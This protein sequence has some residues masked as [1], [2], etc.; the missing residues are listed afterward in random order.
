MGPCLA[1]LAAACNSRPPASRT[2][3]AGGD[4]ATA[5]E[6]SAGSAACAE[7]CADVFSTCDD[8][9]FDEEQ[10]AAR[11]IEEPPFDDCV[12]ECFGLC[13]CVADCYQ[14]DVLTCA[15]F[16]KWIMINECASADLDSCGKSCR[17]DSAFGDCT[18]ACKVGD[19]TCLRACL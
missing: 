2:T 18:R 13:P 19:C 10:C 7:L 5:P 6:E 16:C 14:G 1:L 15:G 12:P 11:C 8:L 17:A 3:S 9:G 4:D